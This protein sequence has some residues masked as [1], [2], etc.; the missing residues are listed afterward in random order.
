MDQDSV[1][2]ESPVTA[3]DVA[4]IIHDNAPDTSAAEM[5]VTEAGV[6]VNPGLFAESFEA[7]SKPTLEEIKEFSST[8][9]EAVKIKQEEVISDLKKKSIHELQPGWT[10][11]TQKIVDTFKEMVENARK[12]KLRSAVNTQMYHNDLMRKVIAANTRIVALDKETDDIHQRYYAFASD[13]KKA[14]LPQRPVMLHAFKRTMDCRKEIINLNEQI[15]IW[16]AVIGNKQMEVL[17]A[18]SRT[19]IITNGRWVRD[20]RKAVRNKSIQFT[21]I[22]S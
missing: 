11:D 2:I 8:L 21:G 3:A 17:A 22:R 4:A 14:T 6:P 13:L 20:L 9:D 19:A 15:L 16:L 18:S 12:R 1:T 5:L 10:K 7:V